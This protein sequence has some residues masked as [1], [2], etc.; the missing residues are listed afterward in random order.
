MKRAWIAIA[1]CCGACNGAGTTPDATPAAA[2][3]KP[4]TVAPQNARDAARPT[5]SAVAPVRNASARA[6]PSAS[7]DGNASEA[8]AGPTIPAGARWTIFCD[9]ITSDDHVARATALKEALMKN[10][11]ARDW[12]VIHQEDRST[13]YLG[14]YKEI[15]PAA[16]GKDAASR[17]DAQ[18]ARSDKQIVDAIP[19]PR[20]A[21]RKLFP[22]AQFAQLD[23]PD[24]DAP[25]EWSLT[26]APGYWSVQV[27]AFTGAERKQ[28]AVEAVKQARA[29]NVM[30]YYFHGDATSSVCVGSWPAEAL[31][32]QNSSNAE[33]TR[34]DNETLVVNLTGT[35]LTPEQRRTMGA[36]GGAVREMQAKADVLDPSLKDTLKQYPE[37]AVDGAVQMMRGTDK[38]TGKAVLLPTKSFIVQIPHAT[39]RTPS[40]DV[41]ASGPA[42]PRGP[43]GAPPAELNQRLRGIGQ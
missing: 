18:R 23:A 7:T 29:M 35:D 12:Y 3:P 27:A 11:R 14:Y 39:L 26:N 37:H 30:A 36:N 34:D 15:D 17:A 24:P 1:L 33:S 38:K 28:N 42:A 16:A 32:R 10:A 19:S 21:D 20:G 22:R 6:A 41:E 4:R 2:T 13:I 43:I 31:K 40:N 8:A 5:A 9:S 25:A